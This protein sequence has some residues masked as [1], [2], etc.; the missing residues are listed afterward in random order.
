MEFSFSFFYGLHRFG[1]LL[2]GMHYT[3]GRRYIWFIEREMERERSPQLDKR[4]ESVGGG[5]P[6]VELTSSDQVNSGRCH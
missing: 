2:C 5:A 4:I 3:L 6:R 1:A